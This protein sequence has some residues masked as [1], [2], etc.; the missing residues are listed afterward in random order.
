MRHKSGIAS[1]PSNT[2]NPASFY[3]VP[4]SAGQA[5]QA[6]PDPAVKAAA[7][8]VGL[9]PIQL[10]P[11][12]RQTALEVFEQSGLAPHLTRANPAVQA[13]GGKRARRFADVPLDRVQSVAAICNMRRSDVFGSRQQIVHP[14]RDEAAERDLERQ[15]RD[16]ETISER[17]HIHRHSR[18]VDGMR[19]VRI[20]LRLRSRTLHRQAAARRRSQSHRAHRERLARLIRPSQYM[21]KVWA[22]LF[23]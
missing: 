21:G 14:H 16:V 5:R 15:T 9:R 10:D 17:L 2:G 19:L 8:S 4:R 7:R 12:L 13:K 22:D 1:V 11:Q 23:R 20:A 18:A 6:R 3:S